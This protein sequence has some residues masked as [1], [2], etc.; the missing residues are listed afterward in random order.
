MHHFLSFL[1]LPHVCP[2]CITSCLISL[3]PTWVHC[4]L[5]PVSLTVPTCGCHALLP[6]S[7]HCTHTCPLCITSCLPLFPPV[8][9]MYNF[10]SITIPICSC[11][12]ALP[13]SS[14][15]PSHVPVCHCS[16]LCSRYIT[17]FS[18]IIPTCACHAPFPVCYC[19]PPVLTMPQTAWAGR[20]PNAQLW[21]SSAFL[22][23]T[24]FS[25]ASSV[26]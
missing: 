2:P 9:T 23:L 17:S 1:T 13:I 10:L 3:S 4:S 22:L 7:F 24:K 19:P 6:V 18:V 20:A 12:A 25:H 26:H 16:H 11:H 15:Y 21:A 5:L 14:H 8:P